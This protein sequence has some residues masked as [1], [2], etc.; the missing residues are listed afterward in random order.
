MCGAIHRA[1]GPGLAQEC[2]RKGPVATGEAVLTAGYDLKARSVIH[3][4]GPV[5]HGGGQGEDGLLASSYRRALELA[6]DAG[7]RTI[8]FPAISTGIYGFPADRAAQIAV[9]TVAAFLGENDAPARVVLCC[10][11]A[12]SAALHREALSRIGPAC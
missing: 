3:A 12:E 8:A 6:R 7:V 4:V 1:A 11:G 2:A 5:W 10:F 9:R